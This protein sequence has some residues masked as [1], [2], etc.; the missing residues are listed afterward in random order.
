MDDPPPLNA[1]CGVNVIFVVDE[2]RS[3]AEGKRCV[4]VRSDQEDNKLQC[5]PPAVPNR[6]GTACVCPKGM[7]ASG[8][9]CLEPEINI[10][11]PEMDLPKFD[12]PGGGGKPR[13]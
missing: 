8:S 3:I 6:G 11:L 2:S 13:P 9:R 7:I 5:R 4:E 1:I 10:E 12:F